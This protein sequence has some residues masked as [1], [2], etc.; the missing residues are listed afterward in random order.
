LLGAD[1]TQAILNGCYIHGISVWNLQGEAREQLNLV[2]TRPLPPHDE[3]L[4]TVDD[5]EIAQFIYL[6]LNNT[7]IRKVIDTMTSKADLILGRFTSERMLILDAIRDS[8]R[9]KGFLPILF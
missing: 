4:L 2:I 1:V 7:A 8:L 5:L 6:L 9:A 3:P